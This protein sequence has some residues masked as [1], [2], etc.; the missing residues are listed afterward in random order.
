MLL[1]PSSAEEGRALAQPVPGWWSNQSLR[2]PPIE[3]FVSQTCI[4]DTKRTND[5]FRFTH[6]T[7]PVPLRGTSPPDLRRGVGKAPQSQ[8]AARTSD[9]LSAWLTFDLV[10]RAVDHYVRF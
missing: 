3:G 7:T 2:K 5:D 8:A 6:Q 10:E 9:L 4:I 1:F